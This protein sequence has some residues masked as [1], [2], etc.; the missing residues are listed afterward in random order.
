M[1]LERAR[2]LR[3]DRVTATMLVENA[4]MRHLL[5]GAGYAILADRIDAGVE[6][7]VLDPGAA[8]SVAA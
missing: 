3:V 4:P 7:I 1:V 5:V 8:R 6:E 2:S